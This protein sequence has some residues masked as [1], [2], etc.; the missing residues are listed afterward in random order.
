MP[1][2]FRRLIILL[3]VGTGLSY[4]GIG[5]CQIKA[6]E[7]TPMA[8]IGRVTDTRGQ[9]LAE[10][11][12][13]LLAPQ[14]PGT[15]ELAATLS[16]NQGNFYF[17]LPNSAIQASPH[18]LVKAAKP[19]WRPQQEMV[20]VILGRPVLLCLTLAR[21][22]TPAAAVAASIWA[23]V[24][25]LSSTHIF[26][27]TL[28]A[29]LG[30]ALML[31]CSYTLGTWSDRWFI[32]SYQ[33]MMRAL[34]LNAFFALL[35]IMFFATV[36]KQ[37]GVLS[38]LV[39]SRLRGIRQ[40]GA[41]IWAGAALAFLLAAVLSPWNTLW[42]LLP[43]LLEVGLDRGLPPK[44][45][46]LPV[47]A[48]AQFGGLATLI[49]SPVNLLIGSRGHLS[50]PIFLVYLLPAAMV[51]LLLATG[52]LSWQHRRFF[53]APLA[54]PKIDGL[55]ENPPAPGLLFMLL[56]A[57]LLTLGLLGF[58][59]PLGLPAGITVL[60]GAIFLVLATRLDIV[61]LLTEEV[62]WPLLIYL[63]AVLMLAAGGQA[64]GLAERLAEGF[65]NFSQGQPR[66][67]VLLLLWSTALLAVFLEPLLL[68]AASVPVLMQLQQQG[69]LTAGPMV[70]WALA[71]G[72]HLGSLASWTG[73]SAP[74]WAAGMG[75][76]LGLRLNF[77]EFWQSLL[78]VALIMMLAASLYL[79]W[80][81]GS[82]Q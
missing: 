27:R 69:G 46:L 11:Q 72:V 80:L 15:R 34:D 54:G 76:R 40:E 51:G 64:T 18:L 23:A 36:L 61:N 50:F 25:L 81:A 32:I 4:P 31:F 49:A 8:V 14:A 58:E 20:P 79:F 9:G 45:V 7:A 16:D 44:A 82:S 70:W 38:S 56:I 42:L 39:S 24:F 3:L 41:F 68:T 63:L 75:A 6:T 5:S 65:L 53:Q 59:G 37:S 2:F 66:I 1:N 10:V 47:A 26:P 33:E 30:A 62:S 13:S 71:L 55:P 29:L 74:A 78:P 35:G 67:L 19:G 21:R 28:V 77:R 60:T 17:S 52:F 73:Y 12:L 43:P 57:G 48:A 22:P